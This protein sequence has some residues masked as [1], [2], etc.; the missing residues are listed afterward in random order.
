MSA[1]VF[2]EEEA[3]AFV[4]NQLLYNRTQ[5]DNSNISTSETSFLLEQP[6]SS[7]SSGQV[8]SGYQAADGHDNTEDTLPGSSSSQTDE[9][10]ED[11]DERNDNGVLN[12]NKSR[13]KDEFLHLPCRQQPSYKLAR[14]ALLINIIG[15]MS[16]MTSL[17]DAIVYL[18]C[19]NHFKNSEPQTHS[20]GGF[21]P[22][23]PSPLYGAWNSKQ[24]FQ[25]PRCFSPD[26]S[27]LVGVFQTYMTTSTA[28][29][30][31]VIVPFLCATSD[32]LGRRPIFMWTMVCSILSLAITLVCCVF[33]DKVNYKLFLV[34]SVLDGIGGS[35]SCLVIL[36]SSYT[37]DCVKEDYRAG[38]LSILDAYVFAGIALGPML[39]SI[40]LSYTDHNLLLL[41]SFSMGCQVIGLLI[42]IFI[43]PES[44]SESARR[45]SLT[46]HLTRKKSF[47]DEQ[48]R[49]QS[50]HSRPD[51]ILMASSLPSTTE[52]VI[53]KVRELFHH[54]NVFGPLKA[55]SFS[56]IPDSRTRF[57][58]FAL[59][60]AQA[61][62]TELVMAS[63]P[64]IFLYAK[65]RFG[66]TSVENGYFISVLGLSRFIILSMVLPVALNLA[67]RQWAHSASRVDAIDKRL[68]QAGLCCSIVGYFL[69]AEAPTGSAFMSAVV[70]L[71]LGSGSAPLLRNAIIKHAPKD[72]VGEV[73]GAASLIARLENILVP[74]I[75][76]TIYNYTVKHRAQAIIE[77]I[78]AVEF[79]V[80]VLLSLMYLEGP[81]TIHDVESLVSNE[82]VTAETDDSN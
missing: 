49:R 75:F 13:L 30:G 46:E 51:S 20:P 47:I 73:L 74:A 7:D 28:I 35:M 54:I 80:L 29:L 55:L 39:G 76:A 66:W 27:A 17:I 43:L 14:I 52:S 45:Q 63:M 48:R 33:P 2:G 37:S 65:V 8:K 41:F 61:T 53:E 4:A 58:I 38:L 59:I 19:Q 18:V 12:F 78:M 16:S 3:T 26:V 10:Q 22:I 5:G 34:S 72:R 67:H 36:C 77:V 6:H 40:I 64:L 23:A 71:A 82:S 9:E 11:E 31:V 68:L 24:S 56:H 42:V 79:L 62:L 81:A 21:S 44:R 70:I 60:L 50:V 69:L 15:L 57:N 25:D 1:T 32:R